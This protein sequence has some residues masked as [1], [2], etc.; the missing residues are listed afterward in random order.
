MSAERKTRFV[1]VNL[2]EPAREE[3]RNATL[4]LTTPAG[5]RLSMSDVLTSALHVA[6]N[7]REEILDDLRRDT[8]SAPGADGGPPGGESPSPAPLRDKPDPSPP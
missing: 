3:L 7:H 5:R 4:D 8:P 2:T 1:S 6:M